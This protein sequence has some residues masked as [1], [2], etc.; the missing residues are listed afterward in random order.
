VDKENVRFPISIAKGFSVFNPE[1][2]T[3]FSDVF[4]RADYEMYKNKRTMKA[5]KS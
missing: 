4:E 1:K 3:Q 5:S 2:D